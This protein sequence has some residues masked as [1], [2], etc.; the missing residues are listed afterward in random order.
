ME[1]S[2]PAQ[3]LMETTG[4]MRCIGPIGTETALAPRPVALAQLR[5]PPPPIIF[6]TI[7]ARPDGPSGQD[8]A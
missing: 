2:D 1:S 8:L 3:V 4:W 7:A 5:P 6:A